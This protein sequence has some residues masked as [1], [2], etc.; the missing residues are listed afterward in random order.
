MT[1][2]SPMKA[3]RPLSNLDG[4]RLVFNPAKALN[5]NHPINLP[6]NQCIGCRISRSQEWATRL[7]HESQM[8]ERN[9][10]I[11]LTFSDDHL[12]ENYSID[13]RDTQLFM[14]R[15]RKSLEPKTVRFFAC[16]EYG[17]QT[18]R[19]HYHLLVFGHQFSDL[20]LHS[21]NRGSP[22]YTSEQLSKL[23][24]FGHSTTGHITYAS[25]AYVARYAMKKIN[26]DRG[27][28]HYTRIH[29]QHLTPHFVQREFIHMSTVPGIG[30]TWFDKFHKDAFPSD[31]LVV[32]GRQTR[33]PAFY[34]RLLKR[35]EATPRPESKYF[36]ALD[37]PL[38]RV[39]I[40]RA[41]GSLKHVADQTPSRLRVREF[42]KTEQVKRLK[43]NLKEH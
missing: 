12:P 27:A 37:T 14:K 17:D 1:C 22:L 40:K 39:K 20:K 38:H 15:L 36:Q 5:P 41:S 23:W 21:A 26:G 24:P 3:Y 7:M 43:R 28:D 18:L 11:T 30:Q 4:G 9:A 33:V 34:D 2:Y 8:H 6:C 32:N 29:P 13:K 35:M 31:F 25:A 10:F 19:P 42:C 16:G